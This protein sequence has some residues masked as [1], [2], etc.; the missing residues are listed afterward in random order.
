MFYMFL[1]QRT[2]IVYFYQHLSQSQLY[3]KYIIICDIIIAHYN[4]NNFK[5]LSILVTNTN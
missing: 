2:P 4:N 1:V 5:Q 3:F